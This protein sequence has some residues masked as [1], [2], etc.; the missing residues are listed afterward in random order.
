[1]IET[2]LARRSEKLSSLPASLMLLMQPAKLRRPA[3][4]LPGDPSSVSG[5]PSRSPSAPESRS[6]EANDGRTESRLPRISG[7]ATESRRPENAGAGLA[8]SAIARAACCSLP[9][10]RLLR[11][12]GSVLG[13]AFGWTEPRRVKEEA[14][15]LGSSARLP[16]CGMELGWTE[17]RLMRSAI[18][19][20]RER[21][22][23][24]SKMTGA[25]RL[26]NVQHF[27]GDY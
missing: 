11:F 17:A 18:A 1:M 19:S 10:A 4:R 5:E 15:P 23:G 22:S 16:S 2:R 13:S 24:Q 20:G 27:V 25:S 21:A 9:S 6:R 12:G 3:R 7:G 8:S 26:R 14:E